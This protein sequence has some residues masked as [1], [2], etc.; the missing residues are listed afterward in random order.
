MVVGARGAART[1]GGTWDEG[2]YLSLGR[3]LQLSNSLDQ[4]A[5][6]GVAPLPVRL[7]WTGAALEPLDAPV[8]DATVYRERL[9]R[10][11][12]NAVWRAGVPLVLAVY[13][14]IAV[15]HGVA[16]GFVAAAL[17]AL[18]PNVLAHVS[19][20]TTDG[21]F[22]A[23]FAVTVVAL[24]FS[25]RQQSLLS[26]A[27]LAATLGISL[28][29]KYSALGLFLAAGLLF[30]LHWRRRRLL[31]DAAALIAALVVA[32]GAHGWA[33]APVI[34]DGGAASVWVGRLLG[35]TGESARVSAWLTG[36]RAPI[37]LRGIAAQFYLDRAGQ[38]AFLLGHTA[39]HGW[40][41]Y[42]PVAFAVKSTPVELLAFICFAALGL[43][44]LGRD[45]ETQVLVVVTVVFGALALGSH[46]AL[47]V[48]YLLPLLA[49]AV[50]GSVGWLAD[51]WRR[52][53]RLASSIAAAA[54]LLQFLSSASIAPDYLA[55]FNDFSGG[56]S[57]G[58]TKLVDSNL[59]WGQDLPRLAT[60]LRGRGTD[61]VLL[62][63]FGTAPP[64]AYGI[65]ATTLGQPA[66]DESPPAWFAISVT[67]LQGVSICG[68]PFAALRAIEPEARIG[69]T[70]MV[71]PLDEKAVSSVLSA[72]RD[73]PCFQP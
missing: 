59:D 69:Y 29:S 25:L 41:Y 57:Q 16:A 27:L 55:Y 22:V 36:V 23:S 73:Q 17:L 52:R 9:S 38:E 35:W 71:Y 43:R 44:R 34:A 45:I 68:D 50:A 31:L 21:V 42:F 1:A 61:R 54:V 63:Y 32:W 26:S 13:A 20:A 11:R 62:S 48:R 8:N 67:L 2:I 7:T 56:P 15:A 6:L 3:E 30:A 65:R 49:I 40:W 51:A 18:S 46:R 37:Y 28:A 24:V 58:Y 14:G 53:P 4:F 33:V 70:M 19:L 64:A 12:E 10:A 5:A 72:A 60:W 47:G 66:V 39:Q